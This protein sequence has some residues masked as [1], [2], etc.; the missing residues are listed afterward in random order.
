MYV[1]P[2]LHTQ[3]VVVSTVFWSDFPQTLLLSLEVVTP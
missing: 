1:K 2:Q 3:F